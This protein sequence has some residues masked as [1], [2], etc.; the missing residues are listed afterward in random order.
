MSCEIIMKTT[1]PLFFSTRQYCVTQLGFRCCIITT[2]TWACRIFW[3]EFLVSRVEQTDRHNETIRFCSI[4]FILNVRHQFRACSVARTT[5]GRWS[6]ICV[7]V[8]VVEPRDQPSSFTDMTFVQLSK[9]LIH[10]LRRLTKIFL[11][12]I[13][14]PIS[15][16]CDLDALS[17]HNYST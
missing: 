9:S 3:V 10:T 16:T 7:N 2:R 1:S 5:V 15:S 4:S 6:L 11:V 12:M 13:T 8:I 14:L 17:L